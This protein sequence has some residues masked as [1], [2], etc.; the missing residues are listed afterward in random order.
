MPTLVYLII[1][2]IKVTVYAH[3]CRITR[4]DNQTIADCTRLKLND[5][6][7]D[8]PL[9]IAGL[10]LSYNQISMIQNDVFDSFS[11]LTTLTMDF[12][13]LHT[14]YGDVFKG[15]KQLRWLSMN[16]N[17]LNISSF[18][19]VLRPLLR[20]QHLDIRY[21]INKTLNKVEP[22]VYPY[23]GN[24][25]YLTNLYMDLAQKTTP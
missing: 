2:L 11:N 25:T 19:I 14:I 15:L 7:T 17:H 24:L 8:L 5:V 16:H 10:D 18:D 1:S 6:P 12:N 4:Q 3:N 13:N 21:N 23:F 22:M 20:L 9:D